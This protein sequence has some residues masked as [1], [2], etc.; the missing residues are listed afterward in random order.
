[1]SFLTLA[2]V[3]VPTSVSGVQEGA[4]EQIGSESRAYAGNLRSTVRG[5]KRNWSVTTRPLTSTEESNIRSAI[6]TGAF[7][8]M[9]GDL[10]GGASLTVS[11]TI[12][13]APAS[14]I[15]GGFRNA[16]TLAIKEV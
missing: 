16:L 13:S 1:M 5:Q 11:A 15:K 8:T 12:N 6:A 14:K 9:S 2:G 3:T 10:I 7:V 4:I